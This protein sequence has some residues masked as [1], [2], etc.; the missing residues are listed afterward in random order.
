MPMPMPMPIPI[1]STTREVVHDAPAARSSTDARATPSSSK[2]SR[3]SSKSS[4]S[5]RAVGC[6]DPK[7]IANGISVP[8]TETETSQHVNV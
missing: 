2:P 4:T 1:P 6:D 3:S 8:E 5:R 7:S